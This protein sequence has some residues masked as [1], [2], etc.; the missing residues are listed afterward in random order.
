MPRREE[1]RAFA[2]RTIVST[3]PVVAAT[4]GSEESLLAVEWAAREAM[5][6]GAPLKIVSAPRLVLG[7]VVEETG[8]G[9]ATDI[10]CESRDR[11]LARAA[12]RAAAAAP[13]L[14]TGI[15]K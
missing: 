7:M 13:G 15:C 3:S 6:R 10:L 12:Q 11:A 9:A 8:F 5:L 4:D 1:P 14:D 2:R